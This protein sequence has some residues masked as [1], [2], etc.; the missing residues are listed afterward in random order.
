MPSQ[1]TGSGAISKGIKI[2]VR[3]EGRKNHNLGVQDSRL[4]PFQGSARKNCMG[5]GPGEKRDLGERVN[6]Q[7]SPPPHSAMAHCNG[8]KAKAAGSLH[9]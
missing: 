8:P 6:L 1:S 3:Q 2:I 9:G 7:G 4:W 5:Y